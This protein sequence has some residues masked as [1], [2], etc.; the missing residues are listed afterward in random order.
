M[1][2]HWSSTQFKSSTDVHLAF[3]Y[4]A[5]SIYTRANVVWVASSA[6]LAT[7]R[8]VHSRTPVLLR[9]SVRLPS[10]TATGRWRERGRIVSGEG[11]DPIPRGQACAAGVR[12]DKTV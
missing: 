10:V 1:V 5:S 6:K 2:R 3:T 9:F 11:L 8:S 4:D 7:L 12:K